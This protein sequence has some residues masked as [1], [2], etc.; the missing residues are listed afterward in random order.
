MHAWYTMRNTGAFA[1][2]GHLRYAL[3]RVEDGSYDTL[4]PPLALIQASSSV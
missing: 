3:L 2:M 4:A 1:T